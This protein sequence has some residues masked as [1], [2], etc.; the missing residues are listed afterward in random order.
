MSFFFA[1]KDRESIVGV[2]FPTR[3]LHVHVGRTLILFTLVGFASSILQNQKQ[4]L[5]FSNLVPPRLLC[6]FQFV[7]I[8]FKF[9]SFKYILC[10]GSYLF[11]FVSS[12]IL[13][14]ALY[15]FSCSSSHTA[16]ITQ[17]MSFYIK[18]FISSTLA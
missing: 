13:T 4:Q 15:L 9:D 6:V 8:A 10:V 16:S 18:H 17:G 12:S 2:A 11:L 7:N 3:S 14:V 5:T 1:W